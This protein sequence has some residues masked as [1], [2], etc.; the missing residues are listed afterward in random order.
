M[1][2]RAFIKT[3]AAL[4]AVAAYAAIPQSVWAFL[5]RAPG[6]KWRVF[7]V[8]TQV[9]VLKSAGT[10]RIWLPVPLTVDTDYQKGHGN[11]WEAQGATVSYVQDKKYGAGI[12][13]A[14]FPDSVKKPVLQLTSRFATRDNLKNLEK[15]GITVNEDKVALAL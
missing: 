2:R 8:T 13:H 9:D 1:D 4:P 6:D 7:E 5:D 12:V 14:E 11:K 10:T 15:P 3:T